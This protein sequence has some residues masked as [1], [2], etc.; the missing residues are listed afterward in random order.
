MVA[1]LNFIAV[2]FSF[3]LGSVVD[4]NGIKNS[5]L[6]AT[7]MGLIGFGLL[8]VF[9]NIIIVLSIIALIIAPMITVTQAS[10]RVAVGKYTTKEARSFAFSI[11]Y[12][13]MVISN[14]FAKG[15]KDFIFEKC[16]NEQI[17]THRIVFATATGLLV[18]AWLLN[19]LTRELDFQ[20]SGTEIIN[21]YEIK[22]ALA[23]T[24]EAM[25][26]KSFWKLL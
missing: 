3:L 2:P 13:I 9:T 16:D 10:I 22:S 20:A 18:I 4:Q 19:Y 24:K 15:L 1:V 5:L 17:I 21:K 23:L 14:I 12:A 25:I 8:C 26:L 6:F 7:F 11:Y